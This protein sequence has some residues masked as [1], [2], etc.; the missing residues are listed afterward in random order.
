MNK[1]LIVV[2]IIF[3]LLILSI[4]SAGI[5]IFLRNRD[6]D[7]ESISNTEESVTDMTSSKTTT[8]DDEIKRLIFV[9]HSTGEN[10]LSDDNGGLGIALADADFYVSDT[11][12]GWG[13]SIESLGGPIG[14]Y[15]D[16]GHW[17]N[18]FLSED[19][20]EITNDLYSSTD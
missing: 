8:A 16:I 10:W 11:N 3:S 5:L 1:K 13:P 18:W 9:H 15:T 4:L 17:W 2:L 6:K 7:K 14:D 19:A 12:Y 20:V